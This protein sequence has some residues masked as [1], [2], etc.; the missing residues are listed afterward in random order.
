MPPGGGKANLPS[1]SRG[2]RG[3]S[4]P[5]DSSLSFLESAWGGFSS[6]PPAFRSIKILLYLLLT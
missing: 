3:P 5:Q 1:L 2:F 4:P 6:N